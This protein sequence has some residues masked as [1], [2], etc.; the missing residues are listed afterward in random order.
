MEVYETIEQE[1]ID[2]GGC[3]DTHIHQLPPVLATGDVVPPLRDISDTLLSKYT[4]NEGL[5]LAN[6]NNRK[7][8]VFGRK[9]EETSQ[10]CIDILINI[11][12]SDTILFN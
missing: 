6:Q 3:P 10:N 9:V 7:L 8:E 5:N 4:P 1:D 12:E 11:S 2:L